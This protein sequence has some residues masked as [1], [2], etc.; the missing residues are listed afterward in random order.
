[1]YME[2]R[3]EGFQNRSL[4]RGAFLFFLFFSFLFCFGC[5]GLPMYMESYEGKGIRNRGLRK[6]TLSHKG[7]L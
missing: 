5:G 2:T 4:N 3:K 7:G 6:E 1:M